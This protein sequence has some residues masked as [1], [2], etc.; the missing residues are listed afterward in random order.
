MAACARG[1]GATAVGFVMWSHEMGCYGGNINVLS[2]FM[3]ICTEG[4]KHCS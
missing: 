1:R 2:V 4:E 3:Q